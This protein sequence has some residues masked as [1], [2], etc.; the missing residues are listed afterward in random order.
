MVELYG[1]YVVQ[2][3]MQCE[4]ATTVLRPDVCNMSGREHG[5][6][7]LQR[8]PDFD[9]IVIAPSNQQCATRMNVHAAYGSCLRR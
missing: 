4:E 9:F 7:L 6:T 5:V 2:V 8:T 1:S 3:A